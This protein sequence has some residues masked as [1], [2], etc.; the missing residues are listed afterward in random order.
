MYF[1]HTFAHSETRSRAHSWLTHLGF[2]PR[3]I[4]V[5]DTHLH[6]LMIQVEP[7]RLAAAQMLINAVESADADGF[8]SVWDKAAPHFSTPRHC[9]DLRA[10]MHQGKP[11]SSAIGWHPLD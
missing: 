11:Q 9:D 3:Q 5:P 2:H 1:T 8:P 10:P 7:D 6:R 4:D